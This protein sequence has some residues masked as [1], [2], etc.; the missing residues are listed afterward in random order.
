MS[1]IPKKVGDVYIELK[2]RKYI[3]L[4]PSPSS[5]GGGTPIPNGTVVTVLPVP[6]GINA[7]ILNPSG[8][9]HV[10][11][12]VDKQI[13]YIQGK[14]LREAI[15]VLNGDPYINKEYSPPV[16]IKAD[17]PL[18]PPSPSYGVPNGGSHWRKYRRS[19]KKRLQ[20]SRS[21]SRSR[22]K[23]RSNKRLRK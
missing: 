12:I 11:V 13:G 6:P 23:A 19:C 17:A 14:Y 20:K 7:T 2:D 8:K 3:Q 18:P 21:R 1:I 10:L 16:A 4:K 9:S 5:E 15:N 22:S